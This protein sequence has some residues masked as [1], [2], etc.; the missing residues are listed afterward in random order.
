MAIF[1]L[2]N[3]LSAVYLKK[4]IPKNNNLF[5]GIILHNV[6]QL[7]NFLFKDLEKLRTF[8]EKCKNQKLVI[9]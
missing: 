7:S 3:S 6:L 8:N 1:N 2:I 5:L 9:S 4:H